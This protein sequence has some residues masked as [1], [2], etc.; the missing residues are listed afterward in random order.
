MGFLSYIANWAAE[1]GRYVTP[2]RIKIDLPG[3]PIDWVPRGFCFDGATIVRNIVNAAAAK[4]DFLYLTHKCGGMW[5]E[6]QE[7]VDK[8]YTDT[9]RHHPG[10][11]KKSAHVRREFFKKWNKHWEQG[12]KRL[13]VD[14]ND[15]IL[16]DVENWKIPTWHV[17]D[18]VYNGDMDLRT[19]FIG[20]KGC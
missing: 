7:V 14:I 6:D 3:Y 10:G 2:C 13:P 1:D 8:D 5:I 20:W 12:K 11:S 17:R 9:L 15:Y 16:P 4:H 19:M 18:T